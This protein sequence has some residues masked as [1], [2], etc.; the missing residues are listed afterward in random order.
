MKNDHGHRRS[1]RILPAL[2]V[3]MAL[4]PFA[5]FTACMSMPSAD[6]TMEEIAW[7]IADQVEERPQ[8][9]RGKTIAVYYF[10]EAGRESS[11]SDY[12]IDTLTSKIA[13]VAGEENLDV[14]IVSRQNL[15]R[16]LKELEFQLSALADENRQVEIGK[17][18]GADMIITG[19]IQPIETDYRINAQL[20]E[21][22]TGTILD[23]YV[24]EFWM[25]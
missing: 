4:L 15:D 19:T 3:L 20:I 25:D 8:T 11:I 6:Q 5:L 7:E 1:S 24:Y 12:L 14:Q 16:I 2:S 10:T 18:L 23:A 17:Q 13:Q 22:E 9:F 21:L